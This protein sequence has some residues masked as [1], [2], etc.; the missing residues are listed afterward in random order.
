MI[1]QFHC[2]NISSLDVKRMVDFYHLVLG[3]PL[4]TDEGDLD[5]ASLGFSQEAPSIVIWD[6]NRWG[7]SSAKPVTF[8]FKCDDMEQ[9]YRDLSARG[10][11]PNPIAIAVWGGKELTLN[12]PDGNHILILE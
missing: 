12:D 11:R 1:T 4:L 8:V 3:I 10:A 5:G 2:I 9:T 6:E 7:E